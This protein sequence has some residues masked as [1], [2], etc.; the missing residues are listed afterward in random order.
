[1]RLGQNVCFGEFQ[2]CLKMGQ[3]RSKTRS[4]GQILEKHCVHAR[5]YIFSQVILKHSQ[6]VCLDKILDEIENRLCQVK[7]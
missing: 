7:N 4:E 5:G 3:V 1:M 6:S 2:T